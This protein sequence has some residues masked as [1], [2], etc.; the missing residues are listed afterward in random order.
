MYVLTY[1]LLVL[2]HWKHEIAVIPE[3][4]AETFPEKDSPCPL[5][6]KQGV[7][8]HLFVS[9]ETKPSH[10]DLTIFHFIFYT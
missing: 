2:W 9:R 7:N 8:F 3:T 10:T 1:V 6:L 5:D 4:D